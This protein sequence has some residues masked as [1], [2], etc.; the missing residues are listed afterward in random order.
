MGAE[1]LSFL[2]WLTVVL[3]PA[4]LERSGA[5]RTLRLP[6]KKEI[7]VFCTDFAKSLPVGIT[8]K[9]GASVSDF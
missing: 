9:L 5:A 6:V 7:P 3:E 4:V 1:C 2:P 8:R